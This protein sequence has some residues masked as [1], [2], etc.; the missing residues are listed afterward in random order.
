FNGFI[1][2]SIYPRWNFLLLAINQLVNHLDKVQTMTR[3]ELAPR[4]IIRTSIGSERPLH[5]QH[6]HVGDFS[7][8]IRSMCSTIEVVRLEEPHEIVPAY[9]KALTRNDGR[10]TILVEYGDYYNEK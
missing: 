3:A 9:Q 10:S 2:I 4:V 1:P 8:A 6:Q 7:D 5:P